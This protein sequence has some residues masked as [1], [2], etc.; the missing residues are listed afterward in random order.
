MTDAAPSACTSGL[1]ARESDVGGVIGEHQFS[2]GAA[3]GGP[4][5]TMAAGVD[6]LA[7]QWRI[8]E[9][10]AELEQRTLELKVV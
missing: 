8:A 6:G 5:L 2:F 4:A 3:A 9:A 7:A 1:Q 10:L